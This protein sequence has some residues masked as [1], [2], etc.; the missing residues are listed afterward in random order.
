MRDKGLLIGGA[1]VVL[2]LGLLA[3]YSTRQWKSKICEVNRLE[4][5]LAKTRD[6]LQL[7]RHRQDSLWDRLYDEQL[8]RLSANDE[9]Q[10]YLDKYYSVREDWD[11]YVKEKLMETN[12]IEGDNP[13]VPYAGM[14]GPVKIHTARILNHKWL[15]ASFTDGKAWGEMLVEYEPV[16]DDSI[17]FETIKAVLYPVN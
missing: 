5:T 11:A 9:A 7:L 2:L 16:K 10:D 17:R 6:S 12:F 4:E 14:Y 8:F 15:I 1:V 3:W 13:L